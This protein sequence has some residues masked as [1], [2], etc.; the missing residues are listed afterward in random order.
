M[1]LS[2]RLIHR[3]VLS[4]PTVI[5]DEDDYNQPVAGTPETVTLAGFLYPTSSREQAQA[6]QAG[7]TV[8]DYQLVLALRED[9]PEG[10]WVHLEP[11]DG[12]RY[13]VQ[14]TARHAYGRDPLLVVS[15]R[16]VDA[17]TPAMTS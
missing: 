13:E 11:D 8:A 2:D 16:R 4:T 6:N 5:V 14:G 15:L 9:P 3:V 1:P 7:A 12:Q 10:S 17:G